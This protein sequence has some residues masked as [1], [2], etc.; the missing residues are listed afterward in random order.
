MVGETCPDEI[1]KI[2]GQNIY[3]PMGDEVT[4][5]FRVNNFQK[6]RSFVFAINYDDN[7][8]QYISAEGSS[9]SFPS[10][11]NPH[12][13]IIL[14]N[15]SIPFTLEDSTVIAK[16]TFT[17]L[18]NSDEPILVTLDNKGLR[19]EAE[20]IAYDG[21]ELESLP[22][23]VI[24][25]KIITNCTDQNIDLPGDLTL[26]N[27]ENLDVKTSKTIHSEQEV[28][29]EGNLLYQAG[30][31]ILLKENFTIEKP[32]VL[33]VSLDNC[34]DINKV[35]GRV[36]TFSDKPVE[37]LRI[38]LF[39]KDS[40]VDFTFTD[41]SGTYEF[42]RSDLNSSNFRIVP[43]YNDVP[44]PIQITALDLVEYHRFKILTNNVIED[45]PYA[46]I[47][48][49]INQNM[50]I[51]HIDISMAQLHIL[52]WL[53]IPLDRRTLIIDV[54]QDLTSNNVYPIHETINTFPRR[55]SYDFIFVVSGDVNGQ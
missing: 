8:L 43:I 50:I 53:L 20:F 22:Y 3:A 24:S 46:F 4:M 51:D 44:L 36:L 45:N 2:Y 35:I 38:Q 29:G 49:D 13:I 34:I 47:A 17:V 55:Q 31:K 1:L 23:C 52:G 27:G 15:I 12:S 30:E 48:G 54:A 28:S 25:G 11:F 19:G 37:G 42:V 6:I 9:I 39:L 32:A 21:A 7:Y 10:T 14:D 5:E 41:A 40:L 16:V 26:E 33:T 18:Q